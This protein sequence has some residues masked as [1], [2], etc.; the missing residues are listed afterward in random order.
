LTKLMVKTLTQ[1]KL[2]RKV[3]CK[4]FTCLLSTFVNSI[5]FASFIGNISG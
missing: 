5:T 3:G 4:P 2:V 1:K